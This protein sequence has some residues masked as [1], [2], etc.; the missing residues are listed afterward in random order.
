MWSATRGDPFVMQHKSSL[1][2]R[3]RLTELRPYRATLDSRSRL[4]CAWPLDDLSAP[5]SDAPVGHSTPAVVQNANRLGCGRPVRNLTSDSF[6]AGSK[7]A[8][9]REPSSQSARDLDTIS[10]V[11]VTDGLIPN[12]PY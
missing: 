8:D 4:S 1:L 2:P 10:G 12:I 9:A 7:G 11:V 5:L 3:L 6:A